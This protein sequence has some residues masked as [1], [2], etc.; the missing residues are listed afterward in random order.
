[1]SPRKGGIDRK[2]GRKQPCRQQVVSDASLTDE[3]IN[4]IKTQQRLND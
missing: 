3:K 1:M 2:S 4:I